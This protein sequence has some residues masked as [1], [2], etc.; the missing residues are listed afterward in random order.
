[1][2]AKRSSSSD[3][4]QLDFPSTSL[5][6]YQWEFDI[7]QYSK[8]KSKGERGDSEMKKHHLIKTFFLFA[9]A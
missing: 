5:P 9:R 2:R 7:F 6:L 8:R 1:M 4:I 3:E